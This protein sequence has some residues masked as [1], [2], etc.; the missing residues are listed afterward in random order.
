MKRNL[1]CK[2]YGRYV[3]DSY[4]VSCNKEWLLSLIPNIRAFLKDVLAL[5]MHMGK[6]I[7]SSVHNGV[8][9]LGVYVK[10]FRS[11]IAR[12][13][14]KRIEQGMRKMDF[15]FVKHAVRTINSYLGIMQHTASYNIRKRLFFNYQVMRLGV[16]SQDM[17]KIVRREEY[18]I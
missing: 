10:P 17:S 15:S 6:T 4:I 8:E 14:L 9:F 13:T 7:V 3:D 16:F 18:F 12:K 2:H 5:D 11:Y 1:G